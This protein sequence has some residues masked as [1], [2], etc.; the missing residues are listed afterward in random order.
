MGKELHKALTPNDLGLTG[1]HQAGI[2]V[3]KHMVQHF[4]PLDPSMYNPD[5]W[6]SVE[7]NN[8]VIYAWR[9][10]Y[11]NNRLHSPNGTRNEYRLAHVRGYLN[12]VIAAPGDVLAIQFI[13]QLSVRV[14]LIPNK[15]DLILADGELVINLGNWRVI[16]I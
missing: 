4:P 10:V 5:C 3:P 9:Y 14:H 16:S 1:S 12:S 15:E 7:D 8:S 13:D 6:I 11:Y 2:A